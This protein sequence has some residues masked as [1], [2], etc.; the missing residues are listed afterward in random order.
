MPL[1]HT[2]F[3]PTDCNYDHQATF[4]EKGTYSW[5]GGGGGGG[6]GEFWKHFVNGAAKNSDNFVLFAH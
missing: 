2:S 4:L 3:L 6:G 1:H 5:G